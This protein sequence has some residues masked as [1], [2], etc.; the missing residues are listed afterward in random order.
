MVT[1]IVMAHMV[2]AYAMQETMGTSMYVRTEHEYESI[3]QAC[4]VMADISMLYIPM[5][6]IV[7]ARILPCE[8]THASLDTP[9]NSRVETSI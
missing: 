8:C 6:Y 5:A 1:C 9:C 7:M 2:V 4:I 3:I